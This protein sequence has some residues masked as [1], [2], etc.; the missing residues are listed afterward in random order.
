LLKKRFQYFIFLGSFNFFVSIGKDLEITLFYFLQ[1]VKN[2]L[3]DIKSER[4]V[5][6]ADQV[7]EPSPTNP[8]QWKSV[9]KLS[10]GPNKKYPHLS[11][12]VEV[13]TL[14]TRTAVQ[15]SSYFNT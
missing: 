3:A 14:Q 13:Q 9:P 2:C 1:V 4:E 5:V 7:P 12:A 15:S 6:S 11:K 10:Y 8:V